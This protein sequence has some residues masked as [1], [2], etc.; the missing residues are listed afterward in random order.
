[1]A[2]A[3]ALAAPTRA[4]LPLPRVLLKAAKVPE[5]AEQ[6]PAYFARGRDP[7][8]PR[9]ACALF[10]QP[11]TRSRM[12]RR[13]SVPLFNIAHLKMWYRLHA[14]AKTGSGWPCGVQPY[15]ACRNKLTPIRAVWPPFD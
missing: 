3:K 9:H 8:L 4:Q 11:T 5:L 12:P 10:F 7:R 2:E 13:I 1:M 15:H 6:L 14:H